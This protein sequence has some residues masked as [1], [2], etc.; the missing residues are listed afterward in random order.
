MKN[1]RYILLPLLFIASTGFC[2]LEK[3][4]VKLNVIVSSVAKENKKLKNVTIVFNNNPN[5]VVSIN[6]RGEFIIS[7][8]QN[9]KELITFKKEG[10]V[11]KTIWVDTQEK[12]KGKKQCAFNLQ[13]VLDQ[14]KENIVYSDLN[15]PIVKIDYCPKAKK[16]KY[17]KGYNTKMKTKYRKILRKVKSEQMALTN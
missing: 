3:A 6:K 17:N 2:Q 15:F 9:T 12:R 4:V 7:L 8:L 13:L 1:L 11:S 16:I 14:K 5:Q 10:Y